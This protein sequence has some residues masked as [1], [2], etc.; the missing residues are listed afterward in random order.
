MIRRAEYPDDNEIIISLWQ[1]YIAQTKANLEFQNNE[2]EF[3]RF[4]KGYEFPEG[5]V[6]LA[7]IEGKPAGVIAFRKYNDTIC[8]MKRLFV[9]PQAQGLGIGK[10]L[11]RSLIEHMKAS[12]YEEIRLDVLEEFETA[13]K[14]YEAFGFKPCDPIAHNPVPGTAFMGLKLV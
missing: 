4:P 6:F 10:Q 1:E 14:L 2:V 3:T 12:E 5:G 13:R 8:E 7:E 9:S 11:V